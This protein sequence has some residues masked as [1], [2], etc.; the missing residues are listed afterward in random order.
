[1]EVNQGAVLVGQAIDPQSM[2]YAAPLRPLTVTLAELRKETAPGETDPDYWQ[3]FLGL[4]GE[5]KTLEEAADA[6]ALDA[7]TILQGR[8]LAQQCSSNDT[9]PANIGEGGVVEPPHPAANVATQPDADTTLA[10]RLQQAEE[11]QLR[12]QR[13]EDKCV[14]HVNTLKK[15][16][17]KAQA[18]LKSAVA[19]RKEADLEINWAKVALRQQQDIAS[20]SAKGKKRKS[21]SLSASVSPKKRMATRGTPKKQRELAKKG[22]QDSRT[23]KKLLLKNA[24]AQS[25]QTES[26]Q[27]QANWEPAQPVQ[28]EEQ[29]MA[30]R[31]SCK[32]HRYRPVHRVQLP[33]CLVREVSA[34][35]TGDRGQY[36][37]QASAMSALQEAA[38]AFIVELSEKSNLCAIHAKRITIMPKDMQL[39][40]RID[41]KGLGSYQ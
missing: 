6:A 28:Q 8:T 23:G 20:P 40:R 38:E 21:R 19:A 29:T 3:T 26:Q 31:K 37:Y 13:K 33:F 34:G 15:M 9:P 36:N 5:G 25:G 39:V 24:T 14:D 41:D 11:K 35:F 32:P 4:L 22:A 16:L 18:D 10:T 2:N 17:E 7:D 30:R 1:M 27:Q 12:L